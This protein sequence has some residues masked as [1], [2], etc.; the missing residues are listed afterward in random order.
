MGLWRRLKRL[1]VVQIG[2]G[3]VGLPLDSRTLEALEWVAEDVLE[4]GGEAAIWLAVSP[5]R[6]QYP[7]PERRRRRRPWR[8]WHELSSS[9]H[10]V[11]DTPPDVTSTAPPAPVSAT[12]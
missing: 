5:S 2:D 7:P 4:A 12:P 9:P 10:E 11:G 3:L 8:R 6:R 1:G